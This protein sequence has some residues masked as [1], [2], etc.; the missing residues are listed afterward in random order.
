MRS[1]SFSSGRTSARQRDERE[2]AVEELAHRE[3]VLGVGVAVEEA[4]RHRLAAER[5]QPV[6]RV[7]GARPVERLSHLAARTDALVD[8]EPALASDQRLGLAP[9][10]V[11][12]HRQ[13]HAPDLEHVAEAFGGEQP[14]FGAFLLEDR[15]GR[16]RR[17]MDDL[18]DR[19]I[20]AARTIALQAVEDRAAVVVG[21][22]Q[23]LR[24]ANG[25]VRSEK[26]DVGEGPADVGADAEHGV[27]APLPC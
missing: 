11:V 27:C 8:L 1:Y 12:E 15:I 25:P 9:R 16:D 2:L 20:P 7:A 18:R 19:R 22:R 5:L 4:D 23:E 6:D 26:D 24:R 3:L 14:D 17:P 21:R 13:A 10:D